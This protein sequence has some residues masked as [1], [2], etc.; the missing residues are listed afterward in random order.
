M[1]T[2]KPLLETEQAQPGFL[3]DKNT[4]IKKVAGGC[5]GCIVVVLLV[6]FIWQGVFYAFVTAGC[7]PHA[8]GDNYL[9]PGGGTSEYGGPAYNLLPRNSLITESPPSAWGKKMDVF[10]ANDAA[11]SSGAQVGTW[12]R[13]NGP[14]FSTFTYE[15]IQNS[16]LT[17]YMRPNFFVPWKSLRIARCDGTGPIITLSESGNWVTNHIRSLF[18]VNQAQSYG[19]WFD[20]VKMAQ[21]QEVSSGYPSLTATNIST[22]IEIGSALLKD[23][24]FHGKFDQWYVANAKDN[25][26]P[27]WIVSALSV[28]FAYDEV[29]K[30]E[31]AMAAGDM[32]AP[33]PTPAPSGPG[34][35]FLAAESQGDEAVSDETANPPSKQDQGEAIDV[36]EEARTV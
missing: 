12:W 4:M 29:D 31:A 26:M 24:D 23:R 18:R 14:L 34:P 13:N 36:Q 15:D 21:V 10:P 28:P 3:P 11:T 22:G 6:L 8:I 30:K 19:I 33:P 17:A 1:A 9:Y 27:F 16:K 20:D 7:G 2:A 32:K 25:S 5:C 35:N